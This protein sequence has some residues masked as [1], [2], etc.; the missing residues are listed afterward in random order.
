LHT[1]VY[2]E[3]LPECFELQLI[4]GFEQL[5]FDYK[6]KTSLTSLLGRLETG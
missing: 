6:K 1:V 2:D 4:F 5:S 3:H